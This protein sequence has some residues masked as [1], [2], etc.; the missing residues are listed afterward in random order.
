MQQK[1][2][3]TAWSCEMLENKGNMHMIIYRWTADTGL[4]GPPCCLSCHSRRT[5]LEATDFGGC[6]HWACCWWRWRWRWSGRWAWCR[7]VCTCDA[8][9]GGSGTG[10]RA[11]EGPR[12]WVTPPAKKNNENEEIANE[13]RSYCN[14][15][16][17]RKR[18][19]FV[20]FVSF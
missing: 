6:M 19:I 17:F 18:L 2:N 7:L 12:R 15:G 8:R 10:R 13:E 5:W 20:L 3:C 11:R 14:P 1:M 9:A 4:W 16:D